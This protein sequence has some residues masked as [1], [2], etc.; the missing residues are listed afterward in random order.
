[1]PTDNKRLAVPEKS[2]PYQFYLPPKKIPAHPV[3]EKRLRADGRKPE[4]MR[5]I[6][7]KTKVV[8]R[9]KGSAYFEAGDTKVYLGE[10]ML[11]PRYI[12]SLG[13]GKWYIIDNV[14]T[15]SVRP[16]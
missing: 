13:I 16:P 9:A 14:S 15:S 10:V 2:V 3:N 4:E 7:I 6:F 1:M 12:R 11:P 5:P 8:T